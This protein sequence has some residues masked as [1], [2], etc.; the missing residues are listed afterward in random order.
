MIQKQISAYSC[1]IVIRR[2]AYFSNKKT[3]KS[4]DLGVVC[5]KFLKNYFLSSSKNLS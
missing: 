5:L 3:P 1:E 4:S 2:R